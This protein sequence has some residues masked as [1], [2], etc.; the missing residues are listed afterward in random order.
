MKKV[1]RVFLDMFG[2]S[3]CVVGGGYAIIA[4]A[5]G[6][7]SRKRKWT[8]E[9][10]LIG[11][12]PVFQ[13]VPGI[14]AGHTAVY[15][16]RKVAGRAGAAAALAGVFLPSVAVFSAVSAGYASIPL[17]N[18]LLEAAFLGLRSALTGIL[19]ATIARSWKGCVDSG[20]AWAVLAVSLAA[21][22]PLRINPAAVVAAAALAGAA[23][24]LLKRRF[25]ASGFWLFPLLF[26]K[27][28]LMAFG[29]GYV[30]V[31][32]YMRD[33]VGE[34][35]PYLRL[36]AREF[37][38]VTALTQMTPGPVA[39]NSAT[40][41]GYRIG[42]AAFS[43][44]VAPFACAFAATLALIVPGAIILYIVLGSLEKFRANRSVQGALSFVR[45]VTMS[46]MLNALWAFSSMCV[47]TAGPGGGGVEWHPV[48]AALVV[49][50]AYA[51][52][53]RRAGPVPV[54]AACAAAALLARLLLRLA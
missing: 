2:I 40:F 38:D 16:G 20:A 26:V 54:I 27:Y 24:P 11:R 50:S 37:A 29:G 21:I 25:F 6:F 35:A 36:A 33:F 31:P 53:S 9:G 7:F 43:G 51:L 10:E 19:L 41:F 39:V 8:E 22:G 44:P 15:I 5:D 18:P 46:M 1:L 34:A 32:A 45:P 28:G 17:D 3:L 13:M 52:K 30:L 4:V 47:W 23:V 14:I 12:L 48:A 42:E 49:L